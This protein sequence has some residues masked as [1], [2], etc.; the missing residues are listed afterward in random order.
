M[1]STL[2][3]GA[4]LSGLYL[5]REL[6]RRGLEVRLVE[7]RERAGGIS[8]IDPEA[9]GIVERLTS[10]LEVE[11][12]KTAVRAAGRLLILSSEGAEEVRGGIVATGF[13]SKS[14]A[15]MGIWGDRP[16]GVFHFRSALDLLLEGFKIGERVVAYGANRYSVLLA[17]RLLES[18]REVYLLDPALPP[19]LEVPPEVKAVKA[20]VRYVKGRGRLSKLVLDVGELEADALVL[21][22]FEPWN[23]F[24]ELLAVGHAAIEVYEPRALMESA[25]IFVENLLCEG[26]YV[27]LSVRGELAIFPT[28]LKSCARRFMVVMR[29]GRAIVNGSPYEVRG[30]LTLPLPPG[31]ARVEVREA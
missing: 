22:S 9:K 2:V 7:T 27:E 17:E 14:A 11:T 3:I 18:S 29:E 28:P 31:T 5:A 13:R 10:Q 19:Q 26:S 24:P 16:A 1:D 15:E 12:G 23:P 8:L 30:H 6:S 4:G 21:S 25:E 20:K